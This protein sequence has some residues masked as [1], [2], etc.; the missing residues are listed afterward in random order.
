[1]FDRDAAILKNSLISIN[2]ANATSIANGVHVSRI[3]EAERLSFLVC[4]FGEV[5]GLKE[6]TVLALLEGNL[7]VFPGSIVSDFK[8][9]SF[10]DFDFLF[11]K[12]E[13]YLL[14][15]LHITKIL[16]YSK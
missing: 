6:V 10:H 5:F 14:K 13:G 9:I 11:G 1:M 16:I 15:T 12:M 4:K 7:I 8:V 2:I 3:V